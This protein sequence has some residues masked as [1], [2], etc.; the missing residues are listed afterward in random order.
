MYT[1]CVGGVRL[2]GRWDWVLELSMCKI[3][4]G[5][6]S[7]SNTARRDM[8]EGPKVRPRSRGR[9]RV[10]VVKSTNLDF[11]WGQWEMSVKK[12]ASGLPC[13]MLWCIPLVR[14][15][16]FSLFLNFPKSGQSFPL[17]HINKYMTWVWGIVAWMVSPLTS[18]HSFNPSDFKEL[19]LFYTGQLPTT[20]GHSICTFQAGSKGAS[21]PSTPWPVCVCMICRQ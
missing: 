11:K 2:T 16:Y 4:W 8:W 7:Q 21:W 5:R 3:R 6:A 18:I 20:S 19:S 9:T 14:E 10:G 17:S 13:S 15:S 12:K 1:Q